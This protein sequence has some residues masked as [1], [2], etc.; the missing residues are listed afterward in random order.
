MIWYS[1]TT[2][3]CGCGGCRCGSAVSPRD[4]AEFFDKL[5]EYMLTQS[6]DDKELSLV[7]EASHRHQEMA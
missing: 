3:S 1:L 5:L 7:L 4:R 2:M 6:D